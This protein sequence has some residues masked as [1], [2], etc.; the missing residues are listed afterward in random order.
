[1]FTRIT[2][3]GDLF[4]YCESK[5]DFV[6]DDRDFTPE[7]IKGRRETI[8]AL[9]RELGPQAI[10]SKRRKDPLHIRRGPEWVR[11]C[12]QHLVHLINCYIE[13]HEQI[14]RHLERIVQGTEDL[15]LAGLPR[16]A[17]TFAWYRHRL[18]EGTHPHGGLLRQLLPHGPAYVPNL[19]LKLLRAFDCLV[20]RRFGF[21]DPYHPDGL[22]LCYAAWASAKE[23]NKTEIESICTKVAEQHQERGLE[24]QHEDVLKI[25]R[26]LKFPVLVAPDPTGQPQPQPNWANG[27]SQLRPP[28]RRHT[29]VVASHDRARTICL[30][31][32]ACHHDFSAAD[33]AQR[34]QKRAHWLEFLEQ[35]PG[36]LYECFRKLL[37]ERIAQQQDWYGPHAEAVSESNFAQ[38]EAAGSG[39]AGSIQHH[40]AQ[41][42]AWRR[43]SDRGWPFITDPAEPPPHE[44]S[45][46]AW[47]F[48]SDATDPQRGGLAED[49]AEIERSAVN[50]ARQQLQR[51]RHQADRARKVS[52]LISTRW[53]AD[54]SFAHDQQL[55]LSRQVALAV[56]QLQLA[57]I[58]K[59][60]QQ[61]FRTA[62]GIGV[63]VSHAHEREV[64]NQTQR[65]KF[66]LEVRVS[67]AIGQRHE[68]AHH[69]QQRRHL[70]RVIEVCG[71]VGRQQEQELTEQR[72]HQVRQGLQLGGRIG[73]WHLEEQENEQRRKRARSK[74]ISLRL[75]QSR[76]QE[77]Q[78][79]RVRQHHRSQQ[80][81]L[82]VGK[83]MEEEQEH[84]KTIKSLT[85]LT[86][87]KSRRIKLQTELYKIWDGRGDPRRYEPAIIEW[88]K[89]EGVTEQALEYQ[90]TSTEARKREILIQ[91]QYA[92]KGRIKQFRQAQ[93][94]IQKQRMD[95]AANKA[96]SMA[97][98]DGV[99]A[100]VALLTELVKSLNEKLQQKN[101]EVAQVKQANEAFTEQDSAANS[102]SESKLASLAKMMR[103]E[104]EILAQVNSRLEASSNVHEAERIESRLDKIDIKIMDLETQQ[105][106]GFGGIT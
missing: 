53:Q 47:D 22:R 91:S 28:L 63:Q 72:R 87:L 8:E 42:P 61:K 65:R 98:Y 83:Q 30:A 95:A 2:A 41:L 17:L 13:P 76:E 32:P 44:W 4:G 105:D 34:R 57:P 29:V 24:F 94:K 56:G 31:G 66:A 11:H 88:L 81:S 92:I 93:E 50:V 5:V 39:A 51:Q 104:A 99:C 71:R 78:V 15:I 16:T 74:Q 43:W 77:L 54:Q 45:T 64:A 36:F 9:L 106:Q 37:L 20:S 79:N 73:R 85:E 19:N 86:E 49:N 68:V 12:Q 62:V 90:K 69:Q 26:E 40:L 33:F 100:E 18:K 1:M 59:T 46:S 101:D 103:H 21:A 89:N 35:H 82:N 60:R 3:V 7:R 80:I 67:L 75:G 38:L 10:R 52:L 102:E 27:C 48:P 6:G 25:C 14:E 97:K 70:H 58:T 96:A 84:M 23:V 55:Q